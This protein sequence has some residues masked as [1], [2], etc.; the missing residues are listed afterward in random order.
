MK[1]NYRDKVILGIILAVFI[2]I[3]GYVGLIKPLR[4]NIKDNE[5]KRTEV[6]DERDKIERRI[7]T[8]T[9]LFE[10]KHDDTLIGTFT[11][12]VKGLVTIA[13]LTEGI[14][15]TLTEVSSPRGY[16]GLTGELTIRAEDGKVTVTCSDE[17]YYTLVQPHDGEP[18]VLTVKNKPYL[19]RAVKI[20]GDTE[21]K[22]P[23]VHFAL[24]KQITV[25]EVTQFDLNPMPGY[26]DLIT[27]AEGILPKIDKTLPSGTY[28]LREKEA[29]ANYKTIPAHVEFKVS[30]TGHISLLTEGEWVSLKEKDL[31]TGQLL[32]T[33]TVRNYIDA[34]LLLKKVDENQKALP[35]AVFRLEKYDS[36]WEVVEEYSSIDLGTA[37]EKKLTGLS[38]GRYRLEEIEAPDGY[39]VLEKYIWFRIDS[40][41]RV[42]LTDESGEGT[43]KYSH[44]TM[45]ESGTIAVMTV[46]NTPGAV[47]PEAGG[48]GTGLFTAAGLA[49]ILT[50]V[51]LL[52][53]NRRQAD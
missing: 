35:G 40:N 26:E 17:R 45:D 22:L 4:A 52:I 10:L 25:D 28:Q 6:E 48:Q 23:G 18:A 32:V 34:S 50:A 30:E 2:I 15:Y 43:G 20:D 37:A 47:L 53:R 13:F 27:D 51:I 29:P 19:F 33:L 38:A 21:A 46:E 44:V 11:S 36:A 3:G 12:D 1:L 9:G 14:D 8:A 5:D 7:A 49:L 31:E 41:G 39:I 24:H 42:F 16:H